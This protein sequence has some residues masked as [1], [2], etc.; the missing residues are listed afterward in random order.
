MRRLGLLWQVLILLAAAAVSTLLGVW[1]VYGTNKEHA[2][3]HFYALL[4]ELVEPG[5]ILVILVLNACVGVFQES[6]AEAAIEALKQLEPN[7]AT[8]RRQWPHHDGHE[9]HEERE[10]PG[11]PANPPA[12]ARLLRRATVGAAAAELVPG[13]IVVLRTGDCVPADCRVLHV[14]TKSFKT[15]QVPPPFLC[16]PSSVAVPPLMRQTPRHQQNHGGITALLS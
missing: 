4:H 13:D 7:H 14:Y 5:V 9:T 3:G 15:D 6:S 16:T 2:H 12:A 8:V 10:L 1:D 11:M